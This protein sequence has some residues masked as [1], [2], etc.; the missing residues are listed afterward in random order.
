M[1]VI[2]KKDDG[3]LI[4]VIHGN[5]S[6]TVAKPFTNDVRLLEIHV[7]GTSHVKGIEKLSPCLRPRTG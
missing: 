2:I 6:V 7:A 3:G 4:S 1:S 5:S